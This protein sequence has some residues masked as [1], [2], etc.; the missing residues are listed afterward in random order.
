M[1][2]ED[3]YSSVEFANTNAEDGL[4]GWQEVNKMDDEW[5][6]MDNKRATVKHCEEAA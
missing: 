3:T 5:Q 1:F 2:G 6:E 4:Y